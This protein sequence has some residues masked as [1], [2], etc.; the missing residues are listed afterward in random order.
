MTELY[1]E[2]L[3]VGDRFDSDVVHVTEEDIIAFARDFDQQAF[4][5]DKSAAEKSVFKGLAASGWHTAAMSMK[6]YTTGKFRAAGG[7]VGL[8]VDELRWPHP[9]RPG[10]TLRLETEILEVRPSQSKP[11]RGI[12]RIRNVTTNQRGEIVQTF[13]A[14]VMVQRRPR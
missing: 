10:D 12:I 13:L 1:L 7:S 4:H 3:H 5:L 6:L 14:Y 9:V 8:A 11:N 2:D